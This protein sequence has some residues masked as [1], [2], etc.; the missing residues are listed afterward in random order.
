MFEI[1][2]MSENLKV[3]IALSVLDEQ[4]KKDKLRLYK[5]RGA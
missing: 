1:L 2:E 4:N 3:L 5:K